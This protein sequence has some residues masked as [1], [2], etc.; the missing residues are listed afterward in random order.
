MFPHP[1]DMYEETSPRQPR[2]PHVDLFT[3]NGCQQHVDDALPVA[4]QLSGRLHRHH[5]IGAA[6]RRPVPQMIDDTLK[7]TLHAYVQNRLRQLITELTAQ[8]R[9]RLRAGNHKKG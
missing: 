9:D 5:E 6:H 8:M 3:S 4:A 1:P 2:Q 7:S